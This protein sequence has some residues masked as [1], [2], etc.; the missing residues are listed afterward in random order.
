MQENKAKKYHLCALKLDMMKAYN[1]VAWDYL[2]AIMTKLSF[3]QPV[4][5]WLWVW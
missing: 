3:H 1:R 5:I 2:R 4:L